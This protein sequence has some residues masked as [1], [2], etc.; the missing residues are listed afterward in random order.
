MCEIF[1]ESYAAPGVEAENRIDRYLSK[2]DI[3]ELGKIYIYKKDVPYKVLRKI[4][5]RIKKYLDS[6]TEKELLD[7]IIKSSV[8][9]V[10]DQ[11][12]RKLHNYSSIKQI[13]LSESIPLDVRL[14][15]LLRIDNREELV[16]QFINSYYKKPENSTARK[17]AV[18]HLT[19]LLEKDITIDQ[20]LL[21]LLVKETG[22]LSV[23]LRTLGRINDFDFRNNIYK[24]LAQSDDLAVRNEALKHVK[25]YQ[26]QKTKEQQKIQSIGS[27]KDKPLISAPFDISVGTCWFFNSTDIATCYHVIQGKTRYNI[28]S[29]KLN[30][31]IPLDLIAFDE[32]KD[33]AIL[34]IQS[35]DVIKNQPFLSI[36]SKDSH[37]ADRVFTMGY[38]DPQRQ[39]IN[40]KYTA[41]DINSNTGLIDAP[42]MYQVSVPI[43]KGNSGGPLI[44]EN[45]AVIGLI[46]ATLKNDMYSTTQNVNYA[47]K[48]KYLMELAKRNNCDIFSKI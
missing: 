36:E 3:D 8:F 45:G 21:K 47:V 27:K 9:Y 31:R 5:T 40:I 48:V 41:G 14:N 1:S 25:E 29:E 28:F 44:N 16:E 15:A 18:N 35:T 34:R 17:L 30:A 26:P 19:T 10:R 24:E 42:W 33:I 38:P 11:A 43:Q 13:A 12:I 37:I 22:N 7:T 6:R 20:T 46:F 23:K 2:L 4:E 39:G 32:E